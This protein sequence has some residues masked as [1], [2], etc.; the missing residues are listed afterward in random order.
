MLT[1]PLEEIRVSK[2]KTY[3]KN[4]PLQGAMAQSIEDMPIQA[5]EG[6]RSWKPV[7]CMHDQGNQKA[8]PAWIFHIDKE[9]KRVKGRKDRTHKI[10]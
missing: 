3:R 6:R 2:G 4:F 1:R 8:S 5:N 10:M 7:M 9:K